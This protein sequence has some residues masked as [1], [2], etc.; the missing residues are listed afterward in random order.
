MNDHE[1]SIE[2]SQAFQ[3]TNIGEIKQKL[4]RKDQIQGTSRESFYI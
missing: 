1:C 2:N 3:K 4:P